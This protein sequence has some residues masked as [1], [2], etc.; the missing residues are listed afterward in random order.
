MTKTG[1]NEVVTSF[2]WYLPASNAYSVDPA[3]LC[4][5]D[6]KKPY[7]CSPEQRARII[8]GEACMWGDDTGTD[9]WLADIKCQTRVYQV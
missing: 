5:A 4:E 1:T 9:A 7:Y 6:P 3:G 8:G 2:G